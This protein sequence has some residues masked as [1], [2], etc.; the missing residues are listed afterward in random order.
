MPLVLSLTI[1]F[2]LAN[3]ILVVKAVALS[4]LCGFSLTRLLLFCHFHGNMS[5][6][7]CWSQN[8]EGP[9]ELT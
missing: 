2:V 6:C 1:E 7:T 9:G 8:E 4:V 5:P 3:G